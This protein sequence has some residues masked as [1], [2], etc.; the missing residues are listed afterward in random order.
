MKEIDMDILSSFF[1][2]AALAICERAKKEN[3]ECTLTIESD[4]RL[5]VDVKPFVPFTYAC[6]YSNQCEKG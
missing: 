6:P 4:G 5:S 2:D 1:M 3:L